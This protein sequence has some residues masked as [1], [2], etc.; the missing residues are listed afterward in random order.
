MESLCRQGKQVQVKV[1]VCQLVLAALKLNRN[2]TY[3]QTLN[4][5]L[6]DMIDKLQCIAFVGF[7]LQKN[8]NPI[9]FRPVV[10]SQLGIIMLVY[11]MKNFTPSIRR[12]YWG[13]E[14]LINSKREMIITVNW[15]SSWVVRGMFDIE[16]V[17]FQ[18]IAT[19]KYKW[20]FDFIW[21][22]YDMG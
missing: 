13:Y 3:K 18:F 22:C 16:S 7:G 1:L 11:A 9:L 15:L 19:L 6:Q 10:W 12:S 17:V 4:A 8:E 2:T 21:Y 20:E 14:D 5:W